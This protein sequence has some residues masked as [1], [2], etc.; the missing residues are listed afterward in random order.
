[1]SLRS[2]GSWQ[3]VLGEETPHLSKPHLSCERGTGELVEGGFR[4]SETLH[5]TEAVIMTI[6]AVLCDTWY[7]RCWLTHDP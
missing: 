5:E 4:T 1:M 6:W 2:Y 7:Q 3:V